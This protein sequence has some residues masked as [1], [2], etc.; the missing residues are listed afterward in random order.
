M[1][2]TFDPT[3]F[4]DATTTEAATR[5]PPLPVGDYLGVLGAPDVRPVQGKKDP[6]Q[7]YIFVDFPVTIDLTS[8]PTARHLV[9]QDTVKL[10]YSMS[11]DV[12]GTGIDWSPGKNT[13]LRFLREATGTNVPG[14]SFNIRGLEGRMIKAKVIHREYPENSGEMQD[15][16]ASVAK[17]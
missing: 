12:N 7:T 2:S 9:G 16:I 17:P 1:T 10:R 14:Q 6:S 15:N 8:Y 11:L 4:L 13:G 3:Q 5:R